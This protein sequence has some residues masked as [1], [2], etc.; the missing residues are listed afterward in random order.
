MAF[1]KFFTLKLSIIKTTIKLEY[2]R[3]V[4]FEKIEL[5]SDLIKICFSKGPKNSKIKQVTYIKMTVTI[6]DENCKDYC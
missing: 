1:K 3:I 5:V 6:A 2:Q 4:I